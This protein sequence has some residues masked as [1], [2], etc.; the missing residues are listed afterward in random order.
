MP[1]AAWAAGHVAVGVGGVPLIGSS[2]SSRGMVCPRDSPGEVVVVCLWTKV[3]PDLSVPATAVLEGAVF[4][5]GG[6]VA[7]S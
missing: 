3:L 2:C 7:E 1:L 6:I 5:L 4:L